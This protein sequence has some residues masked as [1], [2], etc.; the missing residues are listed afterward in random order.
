MPEAA[1]NSTL[2]TQADYIA[3]WQKWVQIFRD[4]G[5]TNVKQLWITTAF[6]YTVK[7]TDRRFATAWYPGDDWVDGIGADAYNW[8][9]CRITVVRPW[10]SLGGLIEKMRQFALLHPTKEAWIAEFGSVEDASQ[11]G[12][13]AQ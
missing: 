3:A 9:N 8:F 10:T 11:P 5:A 12:R 2:G 4:E 13:R 1:T 6:A 7:S